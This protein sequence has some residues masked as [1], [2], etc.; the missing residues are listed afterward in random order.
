MMH[1]MPNEMVNGLS[2]MG[3]ELVNEMMNEAVYDGEK[4]IINERMN[5]KMHQIK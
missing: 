5:T 4:P 3:N 2:E 1:E